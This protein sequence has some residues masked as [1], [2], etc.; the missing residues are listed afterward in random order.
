MKTLLNISSIPKGILE[1][2]VS[3]DT[4]FQIKNT[5]DWNLSL[6]TP[7]KT[8]HDL[9]VSCSLLNDKL[10]LN[11]VFIVEHCTKGAA[12]MSSPKIFSIGEVQVHSVVPSS[13]TLSSISLS[14]RMENFYIYVFA[15]KEFCNINLIL[16]NSGKIL[17]SRAGFLL[18]LF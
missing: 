16:A 17:R 1:I 4:K 15:F 10:F 14:L 12:E 13:I 18:L 2:H 3:E 7:Y 8:D 11:L 5:M 6:T 9:L